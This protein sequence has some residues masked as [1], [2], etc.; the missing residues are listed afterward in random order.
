MGLINLFPDWPPL[1]PR[2]RVDATGLAD[3]RGCTRDLAA[4]RQAEAKHRAAATTVRHNLITHGGHH[5]WRYSPVA[6]AAKKSAAKHSGVRIAAPI[7]ARIIGG[8]GSGLSF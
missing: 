7:A 3:V 1:E 5:R 4:D 8:T 6:N 2:Q